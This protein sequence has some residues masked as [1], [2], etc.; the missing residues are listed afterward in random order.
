MLIPGLKLQMLQFVR[1]FYVVKERQIKKFFSDWG[2][3]DVEFNLNALLKQG[4]FVYHGPNNEYISYERHLPHT[5]DF[6]EPCIQAIDVMITLRSQKVVWFNRDTYPS[7]ITFATVD[8]KIYNVVVFDDF[9]VSKY[10]VLTRIKNTP[11]PDGEADPTEYIAVVPNEEIA[12]QIS[13]LGF[14]LYA[15][16]NHRDGH[17]DYCEFTD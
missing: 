2:K 1:F 17:V 14:T 16:V 4:E 9:W 7:E 3:G 11:L 12:R 8:N 13:A 5:L 6:Y 10:A 15:L